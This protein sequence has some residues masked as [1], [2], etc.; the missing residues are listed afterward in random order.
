MS[1]YTDSSALL[2]IDMV[3]D[4]ADPDGALFVPSAREIISR[5]ADLARMA[6]K[7]GLPVLHVKDTHE[8]D[9][10]E[11]ENWPPHAVEGTWGARVIEQLEPSESDYVVEKKRFS[12]FFETGLDGLLEDLGVS[13]LVLTGTVTNICILATAIDALMRGYEVTVPSDAVAGLEEEHHRSALEQIHEV[14]GG[15]VV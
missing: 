8:P 6:R 13:H 12:A 1:I 11:F 4:F 14:L 2:I 3:N 15:E 10:Q 9:D 7:R 5:V